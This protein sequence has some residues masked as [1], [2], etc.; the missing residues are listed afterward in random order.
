[1]IH[2]IVYRYFATNSHNHVH[3]LIKLYNLHALH[4]FCAWTENY[5]CKIDTKALNF[6]V[7]SKNRLLV[8][9]DWGEASERDITS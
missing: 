2:S 6:Y 8:Q 7:C 5:D 4:R 3:D 1:M 9:I